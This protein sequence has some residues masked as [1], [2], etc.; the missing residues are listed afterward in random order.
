[1]IGSKAGDRPARS[2]QQAETEP[3]QS[4]GKLFDC[5]ANAGLCLDL[6]RPAMGTCAAF[7]AAL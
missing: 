7:V 3:Y 5:H 1:M 6:G 2:Q 4:H